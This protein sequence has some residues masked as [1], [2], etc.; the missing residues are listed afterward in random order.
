MEQSLHGFQLAVTL[1]RPTGDAADIHRAGAE[2]LLAAN[3]AEARGVGS[4]RSRRPAP[5][6]C[7]CP[8]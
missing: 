6:G 3:V 7:C 1:S 5:T 2:A 8:P 4:S